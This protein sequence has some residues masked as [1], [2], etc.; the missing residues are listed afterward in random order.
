MENLKIPRYIRWIGNTGIFFLLLMTL[1][2]IVL[3]YVFRTPSQKD[4]ELIDAY[5]MG[6]RYDLRI[7]SIGCLVLFLIG[8]I[9]P[10]HPLR[11]KW[12]KRIAFWLWGVFA[13]ILAVFYIV[14]FGNYAYL[15]QRL[16]ATLLNYAEDTNISLKMA[17]QTY[18]LG[19]TILGLVLI[20]IVLLAFV[21]VLYNRALQQP[22]PYK[23]KR[24]VAWGILFFLLLGLGIFGRIGQ[25][26]LRWSDA[27]ALRGG[28]FAANVALNPFQS[29]FSTL[30]FRHA[31]FDAKKV[32]AG[33]SWMSS[34]LGVDKP[35]S[36]TLNY[37]RTEHADSLLTGKPNVVLVICESFSLY[38]SS[39]SGNP[40]NTTP[41][42]NGL[43][44]QGVFFN[45]CFTP[46]YGTA[47]G[48]WAT[49]TGVP[50]VQLFKTASRNPAA[51]DQH[52]IMNDFNGYEKFYFLGG[53]ASWANL[54][55]LLTNNL[56]ELHLYEQ[57]DY[58]AKKVDVWGISDKN[59][60]LEANK[61]LKQQQKPFFAIVQTADNHRPYTIPAEDMQ[62]FK[63]ESV[64]LD[65]LKKY[66][67]GSVDEYNA[68]RYTDFSYR[69]FIEAAQKEPYFRNTIF[70]FIGDHGIPGDASAILPKAFTDQGL[71]FE[72]VPLL[73]YAPALIKP[74]THSS[75]ASQ[76]DVMPTIAG[77]CNISY[78]NTAQGRNL[79]DRQRLA[80]DSG[81]SNC[82]FIID[83][84]KK[85]LGIVKGDYFYSYGMDNSS[86]EQISNIRNNDNAPIA[87]SIRKQYRMMTDAFYETSRYLLL[88]NK[89]LENRK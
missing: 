27:F 45:H 12:G 16:S 1:A 18:H 35:D 54:R 17:W 28:D 89:K 74:E 13:T 9:P 49:I 75:I 41:F 55:G 48:V 64:P 83:T 22:G 15:S 82:A 11:K 53:S 86:P 51:V 21:R 85:R 52:S 88:N 56:P 39:M 67:F 14:D 31:T 36:N 79:L 33:Y 61:V 37:Q 47:K 80:T 73:F 20:I 5:L 7:V 42:F 19:W 8:S 46:T 4:T 66:G 57:D 6:M 38:K 71:T 63:K 78:T 81:R 84:E 2:R 76:I 58:E 10:L 60:F 24:S 44:Q 72:N 40:L 23:A 34:Y 32:K 30:N 68:F 87:D 77:L 43:C 65:S 50:D 69:K 3:V 62:E 26:P 29:F 25:Y 70:V 59:L